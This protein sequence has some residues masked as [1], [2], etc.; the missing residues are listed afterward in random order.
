MYEL[1]T[2]PDDYAR[3][4]AEGE[5]EGESFPVVARVVDDGLDD[6]GTD[7]R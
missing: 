7:H 3:C 4:G 2:K 6:V 5:E 1:R